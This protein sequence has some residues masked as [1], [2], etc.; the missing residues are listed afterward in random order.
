MAGWAFVVGGGL[1]AGVGAQSGVGSP[2]SGVPR[3][4]V[5]GGLVAGQVDG[6]VGSGVDGFVG[7]VAEAGSPPL[8]G[9]LGEGLGRLDESVAGVPVSGQ[10]GGPA[11]VAEVFGGGFLE[12]PVVVVPE[13]GPAPE[14]FGGLA[15]CAGGFVCGSA[16][17]LPGPTG[18][19]CSVTASVIVFSWNAVSGG[20]DYTAKL[21]LAAAGSRQTV[22]TT[23]STS[24]VFA[25]LSS[26]T[27]YFIGVHSNVGGVAQYYSGVYCTTAVGRPWCGV[28]SASGVQLV[29]RADSRVHQWYVAR[30]VPGGGYTDGRALAGSALSTV[31][32]GLE[33][34]ESYR[35]LFWWRAVAGGPWTQVHPSA[36]C[37]TTAPPAA[38]VV[39]CATTASTIAVSWDPVAGATRYRASRGSGWAAAVGRSHTF[40]NLAQSTT[41]SVRVQGWNSAGWGQT[42]TRAC[43]TEAAILPAP[44]GLLCEATSAQV[45]FSWDP[46]DGADSYSAK[47]QLA[48]AGSAQT[49]IPTGSTS[50]TFTGLAASTRYWASVLAVKNNRPQHFTGVYCTTL[51]D[52]AAPAPKCTAT[53]NSVS[54]S[55]K[56]VTGASKYRAKADDGAWTVDITATSHVFA[57]LASAKTFTI[58]VQAGGA[59]GWGNAGKV[60]CVTAAPGV[61]CDE[62][63]SNSV[64]LRWDDIDEAESWYAAISTSSSGYRGRR[65]ADR[66]IAE[67]S[68]TKF[69]GL[70]KATRYI[71]LLWWY[72]GHDWNPVSPA[73]ECWTKHLA[74]PVLADEYTTGGTT[75]TIEWEPVEGAELYQAKISPSGTSG[76]VGASGDDGWETVLFSGDSHTFTGLE[77]GTQYTVRL[78]AGTFAEISEA[79]ANGIAYEPESAE[80][81]ARSNT[82]PVECKANTATT[83]EVEWDDPDG[84]YQ[85][86]IARTTINQSADI[87]YL[88]TRTFAKGSSGVK[89]TGLQPNTVYWISVWKR[90]D[91]GQS[92]QPV[93]P[94]PRCST[95]PSDLTIHQCPQTA[96]T[97]GTI[98]WTDNGATYYR[99]TRDRNPAKPEWTLTNATSHTFT[100]LAEETTYKIAVQAW[101]PTGWTTK[102]TCDM[103]T[104]PKLSNGLVTTV[105]K[106]HFTEGTIKGVLYATEKAIDNYSVAPLNEWQT[107]K[108]TIDKKRL[109]A[110]MLMIP[111]ME[112]LSGESKSYAP[113]PM[114][115]SRWDHLGRQMQK[116]KATVEGVEEEQEESINVRLFSHMDTEDYLRAHWSPGVGL[117]QLDP[118][119]RT[120]QFNHAE[121][122]DIRTGGVQVAEHL[123]ENHC[124][125]TSNDEGIKGALSIW[126]AC[127]DKNDPAKVET[128]LKVYNGEPTSIYQ[129]GKLNVNILKDMNQVEGGIKERSCRWSTDKLQFTCFLYDLEI[130]EGNPSDYEYIIY[131]TTETSMGETI[132]TKIINWARS[133][134]PLPMAFVSF[135]DPKVRV[136][137]AVWPKKWP[138]SNEHHYWPSDTVTRDK[139][140]YRAVIQDEVVR[141]SPGRDPSP[142]SKN[143]KVAAV[144][145]AEGIYKPFGQEIENHSFSN[146]NTLLEGWY[147]DS[148]P[149]R[150]G[151]TD[152][153]RHT[154]QVEHCEAFEF[155]GNSV[156]LCK[157]LN[158]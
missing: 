90:A 113:S 19:S 84:D 132:T 138:L 17:I 1:G 61:D 151:G 95:E 110:I 93:E 107:C 114:N 128:C 12:A 156:V 72:D 6:V 71:M 118:W 68:T 7:V 56:K 140:I 129:S 86:R 78:R 74:T 142:E 135:T 8:D 25:G 96:D 157:W 47:I 67:G 22:R 141:C 63:T 5:G 153:D 55:W 91:S 106:Y 152:D 134:T 54:V 42:G 115:L 82:S 130:A 99:I 20:D 112:L 28:V 59:A 139:T 105:G 10:G 13:E 116:H 125:A 136:R 77:P 24:V 149:Y 70:S 94:S 154:L 2:V 65:T 62:T 49:E 50:V 117:W 144:D 124:R 123:L 148:V 137:F 46:V 58:T 43:T 37:T 18:L 108:A 66:L 14:G 51:A 45:R 3:V 88:D 35:F 30:A 150:E 33:A 103:K 32:A 122:T 121:R 101:T 146:G 48:V 23:S 145:C 133:A 100:G 21:Q 40:S 89:L 36:V 102:T 39:R 41:Y 85:W 109:A 76:A 131:E 52:I 57:G 80:T 119:H 4:G 29:W 73:P 26:S 31:F 44:T 111:V 27:R 16:Q 81:S 9:P 127:Y 92:W 147:D 11:P 87:Q 75:L 79:S 38:P 126:S 53:S 60:K 69:T 155:F 104:L 64:V 158:T 120:K 98:R 34:N 143:P 83:I 97:D 15:M